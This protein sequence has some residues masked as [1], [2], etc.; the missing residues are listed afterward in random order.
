[1]AQRARSVRLLA[2][3][4]PRYTLHSP[5]PGSE[6]CVAA[7]T[8]A[9]PFRRRR[10]G[11]AGP[12]GRGR[13]QARRAPRRSRRRGRPPIRC[14]ARFAFSSSAST[15][16][17]PV[18]EGIQLEPRLVGAAPQPRPGL[19]SLQGKPALAPLRRWSRRVLKLESSVACGSARARPDPGDRHRFGAA[20]SRLALGAG[21]AGRSIAVAGARRATL[22]LSRSLRACLQPRRRVSVEGRSGASARELRRRAG[23]RARFGRRRCGRP[24]RSPSAAASS[25]D[26]SRTGSARRSSSRTTR[27]SS[28]A[29]AASA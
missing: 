10:A 22:R 18:P 23:A 21:V 19:H 5:V 6:R 9:R 2:L 3:V 16:A 25:S 26:R 13:Q 28:S 1:M 29:S 27:R 8:A 11:P 4:Q 20:C 12:A 14:S 15:T 24:P 17:R 7:S